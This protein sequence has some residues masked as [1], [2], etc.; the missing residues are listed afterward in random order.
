MLWGKT[1]AIGSCLALAAGQFIDSLL[2]GVSARDPVTLIAVT[3]TLFAVATV[4]ALIPARR[5]AQV[6]PIEALRAE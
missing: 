6:D 2:V 1:V 5:A 3:A 4:S